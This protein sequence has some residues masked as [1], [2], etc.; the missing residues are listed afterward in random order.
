MK[1]GGIWPSGKQAFRVTSMQKKPHDFRAAFSPCFADGEGFE[2]PVHCC[3]I[4]FKTTAIDHSA[5]LPF[6][7]QI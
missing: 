2:P 6:E 4:V 3:T 1:Y 5:N 7:L